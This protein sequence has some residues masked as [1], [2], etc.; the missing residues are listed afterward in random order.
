MPFKPEIQENFTKKSP[1]MPTD[2]LEGTV[3]LQEGDF[4][5]LD[6]EHEPP[7]LEDLGILFK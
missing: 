6:P 3:N 4:V 5:E 1:F 2:N 7:L